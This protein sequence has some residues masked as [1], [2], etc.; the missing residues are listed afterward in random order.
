MKAPQ[1]QAFR[2]SAVTR[3]A[4]AVVAI[5]LLL[6]VAA[7]ATGLAAGVSRP[8]LSKVGVLA[9]A[10]F[11]DEASLSR[12][13]AD[14]G[15]ARLGELLKRGG[16]QLV[17]SY[18]VADEMKRLGMASTELISPTR[19][20]TIGTQVGADAVLTGR[21]TLL[22]QDN[23]RFNPFN[24]FGVAVETRVDVDIRILQV[25]TRLIL[26]QDD[27]SCAVSYSTARAAME[28]VVRDVAARLLARN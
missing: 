28:C 27:F 6:T 17:D 12:G 23:R 2:K 19:T 21:V 4:A 14:Y 15:A 16:V 9:I 1:L 11:A 25:G 10:P 26:F 24:P 7:P 13:V 20:V 5:V 22:M 3:A 18:R 8:D